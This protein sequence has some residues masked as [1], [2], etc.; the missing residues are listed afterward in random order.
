S[1]QHNLPDIVHQAESE[2]NKIQPLWNHRRHL[3]LGVLWNTGRHWTLVKCHEFGLIFAV[4]D[5]PE[6]NGLSSFQ[7]REHLGILLTGLH[8]LPIDR[9]E[10]IASQD[11]RL[12][13]DG[14]V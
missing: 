7:I 13:L 3:D 1:A 8:I 4:S 9:D 14:H 11:P 6:F 2:W 5:D 10:D 12:S